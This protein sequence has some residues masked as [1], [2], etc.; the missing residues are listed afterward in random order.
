[1]AGIGQPHDLGEERFRDGVFQEVDR[2]EHLQQ[3]R[4]RMSFS[5]AMLARPVS[6]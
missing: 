2:A 4:A 3:Q 1:M 5:G 6:A